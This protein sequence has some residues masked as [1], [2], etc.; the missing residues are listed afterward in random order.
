MGLIRGS[1]GRFVHGEDEV[2]LEDGHGQI[3]FANGGLNFPVCGTVGLEPKNDFVRRQ[4]HGDTPDGLKVAAV[5]GVR[6]SKH[7]RKPLDH[8]PVRF[9]ERSEFRVR[10]F[11]HLFAVVPRHLRH[12]L[13]VRRAEIFPLLSSDETRRFL[14]MRAARVLGD[15]TD[16]VQ[17]AGGF[18]EQ[19]LARSETMQGNE[20]IK[21]LQRQHRDVLDVGGS[22]FHSAH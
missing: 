11:G 17:A 10:Q 13:D 6:Q 12:N 21:D 22:L 20:L 1:G 19:P 2:A 16:V 9:I 4:F 7:G 8:P 5:E 15:M 3:A 14:M 18:E